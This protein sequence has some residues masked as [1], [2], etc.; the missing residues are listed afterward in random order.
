MFSIL[1]N[2]KFLLFETHLFCRLQM[3]SISTGLK[4]C[5]LVKNAYSGSVSYFLEF[6]YDKLSNP[7]AIKLW[8]LRVCNISLLKKKKK[9]WEKE[10]LL[11]TSNFSLSHSVFYLFREHS[12]NFIKFEIVVCKLF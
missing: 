12:A 9:N 8:F 7:F 1:L 3:L 4:F 2:R 11:V 6:V 5:R 10:K